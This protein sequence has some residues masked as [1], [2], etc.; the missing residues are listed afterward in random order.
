MASLRRISLTAFLVLEVALKLVFV[1]AFDNA[2]APVGDHAWVT[3]LFFQ[4]TLP[5]T[6]AWLAVVAC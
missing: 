3:T 4:A 1:R 2:F 6:T 5:V